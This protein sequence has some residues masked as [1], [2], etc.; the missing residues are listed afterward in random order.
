MR[1]ILSVALLMMVPLLAQAASVAPVVNN[2]TI[3]YSTRQLTLT[4]SGF[5]PAKAAPTLLF[6]GAALAVSSFSNTQIV[7]TLPSSTAPGTFSLTVTNSS[8]N[9]TVF[10][11]SYG[12]TG[13]QGPAGPAGPTGPTGPAGAN[14]PQG[15]RGLTGAPGAP[16]PAGANGIGFSFLNAY[17]AYATYAANSVVTY[18]GS[19]YIAI[20]PNGPDPNG[21][22][23]D[24]NPSWS[25]MAAGGAVGATGPQGTQGPPGPEGMPGP[26]GNPGPAGPTGT[27]GPQGPTGGVKS[28]AGTVGG[29]NVTISTSNY[30]TILSITLPNAG[31]YVLGGQ[32]AIVNEDTAN[33]AYIFCDVKDSSGFIGGLPISWSSLAASETR[34]IPINGYYV[35]SSASTQLIFQCIS[36]GPS[37]TLYS[38]GSGTFTAIQVQ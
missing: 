1:R 28:F 4:G 2:G 14:G 10:D 13:P 18:N 26:M 32:Q 29:P 37:Q 3:N 17:D 20:V 11:M 21:P 19:S 31:T 16:G 36:E 5:Q 12:A 8:G 33:G 23:P 22:T 34:T 35:A 9:S 15:P 38:A 27:T 7:A 25:M 24:Q 30:A 6:N